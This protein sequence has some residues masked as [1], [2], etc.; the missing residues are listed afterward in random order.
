MNR[1][2]EKDL[3]GESVLILNPALRR[4]N[5][6][7]MEARVTVFYSPTDSWTQRLNPPARGAISLY[8]DF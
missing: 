6:T 4:G 3:K 7:E 8:F 5:W 1:K 2:G